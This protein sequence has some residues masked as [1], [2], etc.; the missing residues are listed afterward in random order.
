MLP[1]EERKFCSVIWLSPSLVTCWKFFSC[2]SSISLKI[3]ET[4]QRGL[5]TNHL[6][7]YQ[8][9]YWITCFEE[10]KKDKLKEEGM[11]KERKIN[12]RFT[13]WRQF[14]KGKQG[15]Y[16]AAL[17]QGGE[18]S[19]LF[20]HRERER[21]AGNLKFPISH[22]CLTMILIHPKLTFKILLFPTCHST[23][24]NQQTFCFMDV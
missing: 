17:V 10:Q 15:P 5:N 16:G 23:V 21:F 24:N 12:S 9:C 14:M 7:R 22:F 6:K 1:G 18:L 11:K 4:S 2:W 3:L 8:G 19:R 13:V 20:V